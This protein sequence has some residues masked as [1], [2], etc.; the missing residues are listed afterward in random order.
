MS[1]AWGREASQSDSIFKGPKQEEKSH[2]PARM[3]INLSFLDPFHYEA[4]SSGQ[5]GHFLYISHSLAP[6]HA[7]CT[8]W[9]SCDEM[10]HPFQSDISLQR[11]HSQAYRQ[12]ERKFIGI[13]M[14]GNVL[15]GMVD[16]GERSAIDLF[17]CWSHPD[18]LVLHLQRPMSEYSDIHTQANQW[19]SIMGPIFCIQEGGWQWW[20]QKGRN[21][22]KMW[23]H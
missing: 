12:Y 13:A 1:A 7:H 18:E 20:M 9:P 10:F 3:P 21:K 14:D 8:P 5:R 11:S 2:I 23:D 17:L 6:M 16:R 15:A 4:C 19:P 22:S